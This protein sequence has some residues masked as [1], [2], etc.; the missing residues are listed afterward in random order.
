MSNKLLAIDIDDTLLD[1]NLNI[2]PRVKTAVSKAVDKGV[3]VVLC[4]GRS[5]KGCLRF[6]DELGLDTLLTVYGGAQIFNAAGEPLYTKSL[7][8]AVVKELLSFAHSNGVHAQVYINDELVYRA[9][10][11]YAQDY[12]YFYGFPGIENPNINQLD[13]IITP[14]VLF[15]SEKDIILDMQSKAKSL[16]PKLTVVRSK[17]EYLEFISPDANKGNALEYI[18]SYYRIDQK[19]TIA[20]GDSQMDV[21]MIKYAGLGVAVANA[22]REA[23]AAADYICA[24]NSAGGVA[25]VIEKYLLEA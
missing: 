20:I 1:D 9:K 19:D 24:A 8:P 14:K 3:R 21:S 11:K 10:N 6:Y 4:T 23:K 7:D 22:S 12:E 2:P 25:D 17:P 18:T 13:D 15:V 16:F 5:R